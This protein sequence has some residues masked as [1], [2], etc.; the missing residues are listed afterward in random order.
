VN[1]QIKNPKVRGAIILSLA[2]AHLLAVVCLFWFVRDLPTIG[3]SLVVIG[4]SANMLRK[5]NEKWRTHES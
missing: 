4:L 3:Y 5:A 2:M 1:I